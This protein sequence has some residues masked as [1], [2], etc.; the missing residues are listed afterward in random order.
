MDSHVQPKRTHALAL[1]PDPADIER[2]LRYET[3]RYTERQREYALNMRHLSYCFLGLAY[4]AGIAVAQPGRLW[5]I[6][7]FALGGLAAVTIYQ[8]LKVLR[9]SRDQE[10]ERAERRAALIMRMRASTAVPR[11]GEVIV[12]E[13]ETIT[14]R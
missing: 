10:Q 8:M 2:R 14:V 5:L 4:A 11:R 3:Q 6:Q 13:A 7:W 1:A 9:M 12:S